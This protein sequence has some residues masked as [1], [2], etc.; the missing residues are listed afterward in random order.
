GCGELGEAC[1]SNCCSQTCLGGH[2]AWDNWCR[3]GGDICNV[4]ADCCDGICDPNAHR[5][6]LVSSCVPTN[7][8]CSGLRSCCNTACV[9]NGL[10][11]AFCYP[12][13]GCRAYDDV[14]TKDA[15]CC[16]L[17]CDVPDALGLRRCSKKG[18]ACLP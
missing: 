2:C 1:N 8:P 12:I 4:N 7:E 16:S 13:G 3:S 17:I 9:D 14:C 6:D 18:W 15:D 11:T 10:G 5:C